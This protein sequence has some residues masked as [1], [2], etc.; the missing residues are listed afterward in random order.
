[1]KTSVMFRFLFD[2]III[3]GINTCFAQK[4]NP[5]YLRENDKTILTFTSNA[6]E[7]GWLDFN[8]IGEAIEV[9]SF[10]NRFAKS[11][12][13]GEGYSL[14]L[15]RDKTDIK[16]TRHQ[17]YQL[18]YKNRLVEGGHL[19]LHSRN[20]RL[21]AA[22]SRIIDGLNLDVDNP[23]PEQKALEAALVNRKLTKDKLK[24]KNHLRA[25]WY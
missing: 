4:F 3:C 16:E 19:T 18:Y 23:M 2:Y 12:G 8:P 22:H 21:N 15:V 10:T 13:M 25:N 11:I 1:M 14:R 5:K 9:A 24:D 7:D 17:H 6:T 20:G